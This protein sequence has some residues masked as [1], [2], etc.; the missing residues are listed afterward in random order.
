M[1]LSTFVPLFVLA[2]LTNCMQLPAETDPCNTSHNASR[3]LD[4]L[5]K[6]PGYEKATLRDVATVPRTNVDFPSTSTG[7]ALFVCH[8]TVVNAD[9]T[10]MSGRLAVSGNPTAY[11][12]TSD[13]D[14]QRRVAAAQEQ[15]RR[16][17]AIPPDVRM[18][19]QLERAMHVQMCQAKMTI[20]AKAISYKMSGFSQAAAAE[21]ITRNEA[22]GPQGQVYRGS[23]AAE[24]AIQTWVAE[25]YA[26][27]NARFPGFD[28]R[29]I[30][31][32]C[33]MEASVSAARSP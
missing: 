9:G 8:L 3:I 31:D 17:A 1:A 13:A 33:M 6:V 11:T 32:R 18:R 19:Q 15:A 23:A 7:D 30:L 16:E 4:G 12:F 5:H 27:P 2:A 29:M 10:E 20:I 14:H 26:D 25:V 28:P 22:Y 24:T 21:L